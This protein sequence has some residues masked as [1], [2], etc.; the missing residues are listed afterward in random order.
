MKLRI[1]SKKLVANHSVRMSKILDASVEIENVDTTY[2]QAETI[3]P[4]DIL[5]FQQMC[6]P[7]IYEQLPVDLVDSGHAQIQTA[8]EA[9]FPLEQ[10]QELL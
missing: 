5:H 8:S 7:S 1:E 2:Q 10:P 6:A 3:L 9:L 4:Q